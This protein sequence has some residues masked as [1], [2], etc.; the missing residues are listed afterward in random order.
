[1]SFKLANVDTFNV[2][3]WWSKDLVEEAGEKFLLVMP[4]SEKFISFEEVKREQEKMETRPLKLELEFLDENLLG[5]TLP[6][7]LEAELPNGQIISA[8]LGPMK[9][10]IAEEEERPQVFDRWSLDGEPFHG[11]MIPEVSNIIGRIQLRFVSKD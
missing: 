8:D 4:A 3:L 9:Y 5:K 1:M 10:A 7:N 2:T 11:P 6:Y